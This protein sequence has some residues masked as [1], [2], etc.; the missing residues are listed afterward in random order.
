MY[1][2]QSMKNIE[3]RH[4]Q[5]NKL[6]V[7]VA[8]TTKRL[9]KVRFEIIALEKTLHSKIRNNR[10]FL[11]HDG[12]IK[13]NPIYCQESMDVSMEWVSRSFGVEYRDEEYTDDAMRRVYRDMF[14]Y[15]ISD[16]YTSRLANMSWWRKAWS[17][18][19]YSEYRKFLE[20][21][22]HTDMVTLW[23]NQFV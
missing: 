21:Q 1:A 20:S 7:D 23:N 9:D 10:F 13:L 5:Q 4:V 11:F 19:S 3:E 17:A 6:I 14:L 8:Q 15:R 18:Y 12:Y 2:I 22:E 16:N